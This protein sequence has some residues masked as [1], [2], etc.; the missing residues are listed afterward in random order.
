MRSAELKEFLW[1]G[2]FMTRDR[3]RLWSLAV[4]AGTVLAIIGLAVT[5][6]GLLDY[7][8]RPLGT[9]FACFYTAGDLA[10]HGEALASYD[11]ARLNQALR[12]GFGA[13]AP[14]YGWFYPPSF[15]LVAQGLAYLPY[16]PAL[17]LWLGVTLLAY[18]F[19]ARALLRA[20]PSPEL[21]RDPLWL[22]ATLAFPAVFLNLTHGQNGFLT[23]ALMMGGLALLK[24]RPVLAGILF[25][26]MAYK[27]Q[28]GLALPLA[29]MAGRQWKTFAAAT[30]TVALSALLVSLIYGPG[31]W[32]AFFDSLAINRKLVVEEGSIGFSKVQSVF[33]AVRILGGSLSL[34]Y[35]VQALVSICA[36]GAVVMIWRSRASDSLKGAA[37]VLATTLSTPYVVHYDLVLLA[38]AIVLLAVE[39][40]RRGFLPGEH[41][42]L[43]GLWLVP[44]FCRLIA[45]QVHFPLA[46]VLIMTALAF[47]FRKAR[48]II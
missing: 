43:A 9:D 12:E 15:L 21:A 20:S 32:S 4:L 7:H 6:H 13:G 18:L 22:L 37:L 10:R 47:A 17:V 26:L 19:A 44:F 16:L 3:V 41:L 31:I 33:A 27:P 38:P 46:P 30:V 42:V 1:Q 14:I 39:G 11:F 35:G 2:G 45:E 40:R 28:F 48:S 36:L 8:G 24:P 25:G 23:A 29:L 34:A 5:A